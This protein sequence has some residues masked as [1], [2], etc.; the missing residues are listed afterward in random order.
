MQTNLINA[1]LHLVDA[2]KA[3]EKQL[4]HISLTYLIFSITTNNF[5]TTGRKLLLA[6]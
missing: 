4:L 6:S 5:L 1:C 2:T 3:K